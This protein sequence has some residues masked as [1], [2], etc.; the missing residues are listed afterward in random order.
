MDV[1]PTSDPSP[2]H[3]AL[4][5]WMQWSIV[6][7]FAAVV[8]GGI[9]RLTESGLS[10]TEWRPVSGVLPPMGDGE[11]E[12]AFDAFR[13]IPQASTVH[14]GITLAEF[15][16][17]YWWEWFHR[18]LARGVGLV[19][20]IPYL[21]L[22]ARGAIPSRLK[23]RLAALPLLTL[24]QGALGWYMVQSGL[25]VRTS[26]SAYRLTAHLLLALGILFVALWTWAELRAAAEPS[27]GAGRDGRATADL[28]HGS[29]RERLERWHVAAVILFALVA[30][31][32]ASGGFVAGLDAGRIF[33]TFPLMEGALVPYGYHSPLPWW[34]NAAENPIA[35]QLHHR[36]L[37]I[38]TAL[39]ALLLWARAA[40]AHLDARLQKAIGDVGRAASLQVVLG[41]ATLL[42][43]VPTWLGV[44]H[45]FMGV[46]VFSTAILAWHAARVA[47]QNAAA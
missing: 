32:V 17:I 10:I 8:V 35:A 45:Q 24:G 42:L 44:L 16:W 18:I 25:A 7:V 46:L 47:R 33:N 6:A 41:I 12:A 9:T 13:Q 22:L 26:V 2:A 38:F 14:A 4:R 21:W 20:A 5:R 43:A 34:R 11:W 23:L 27:P 19:F 31:T 3:R 39:V 29:A 37:A 28:A 1:P 30:L 40:R 36:V 15:K